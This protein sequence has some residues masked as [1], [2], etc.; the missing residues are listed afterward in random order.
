ME[1]K[2]EI[3]LE[4]KRRKIRKSNKEDEKKENDEAKKV[5]SGRVS[6]S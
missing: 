3:Q 5:S 2:E 4:Q 1:K 6:D